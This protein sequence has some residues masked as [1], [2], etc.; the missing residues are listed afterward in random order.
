MG[1]AVQQGTTGYNI[2]RLA[3]VVAGLPSTVSGMSMDRQCASGMMAIATAAKQIIVDNMDVVIGAGLES[4][5]LVQNDHRNKFRT[6]DPNVL[7]LSENAYM[8]MLQ[9]AE[10]ATH[11][12][13]P[14]GRQV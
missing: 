1:C 8:P 14:G 4:I 13:G 12:S 5:S 11:C 10:P 3:G 2:G 7:A 6:V 9:T